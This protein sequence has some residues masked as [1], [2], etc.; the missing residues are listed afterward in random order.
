M[1]WWGCD[2]AGEC[3]LQGPLSELVALG[4]ASGSCSSERSLGV[5]EPRSSH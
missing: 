5:C 1:G 4:P 2:N 3:D